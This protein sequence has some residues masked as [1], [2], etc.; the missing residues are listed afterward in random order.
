MTNKN[1]PEKTTEE[2]SQQEAETE[3][4]L[5]VLVSDQDGTAL[6]GATVTLTGAIFE[7]T[8]KT[9]Q[10]GRCQVA[11]PTSMVTAELQVDHSAYDP[12]RATVS[13]S[14]GAVID[15]GLGV[16]ENESGTKQDEELSLDTPAKS[17]DKP[18]D[19]T[20][21]V[22]TGFEWIGDSE[23]PEQKDSETPSGTSIKDKLIGV[24][25]ATESDVNALV[26][27]GYRS[28]EDIQQASLQELRSMSGLD[29]GTALRLKA[30][31]G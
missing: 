8:G 26:D 24:G 16:S 31:F 27:S 2:A 10:T 12:M 28:I 21:T 9:S 17:A 25:G 7:T 11:F 3:A 6:T 22:E 23:E 15:V 18:V 30:E 29:D 14:D 19:S 4:T 20:E 1:A 13:V 5:E